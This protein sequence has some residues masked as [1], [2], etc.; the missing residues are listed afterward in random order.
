MRLKLCPWVS[1]GG[2]K[3]HELREAHIIRERAAWRTA[4]RRPDDDR[5][6]AARGLRPGV[7]SA[8]DPGVAVLVSASCPKLV[9][10]ARELEALASVA[11]GVVFVSGEAGVGKTRLLEEACA[12][13]PALWAACLPQRRSLPYGPVVE[14]LRRR[15]D[16][17]ADEVFRELPPPSDGG[18]EEDIEAGRW[19]ERVAG[20]LADLLAVEPALR[21]VLEDLHWADAAT[22]DLLPVL[23]RRLSGRAVLVLGSYRSDELHERPDLGAAVAELERKRVAQRLQLGRLGPADVEGMVRALLAVRGP[24]SPG[25]VSAVHART[26]G[27][28]LFVEE[29]LRTLVD[30]G[31]VFCRDGVWDRG[32]ISGLPVPATLAEA[33]LRR[34]ALVGDA[35]RAV[36]RVGAVLGQR[37]DLEAVGRIS[38][39]GDDELL[40][41]AR[42]SWRSR[43]AARRPPSAPSRTHGGCT[44]R[45]CGS[46]RPMTSAGSCCT[47]SGA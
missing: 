18:P 5:E 16:T 46:R 47:C 30:S 8:D 27:N 23:A 35:A 32:A 22:I 42:E 29:L 33:I 15:G 2:D 12:A 14:A 34:V 3:L 36:L 25:F 40:A 19:R 21:L 37:F 10:R 38:G 1:R 41:A 24:I 44:P 28:P 4:R 9:G 13:A 11:E 26:E 45:R 20:A 17:G 7:R 6:Q 43:R 31:A 39:I